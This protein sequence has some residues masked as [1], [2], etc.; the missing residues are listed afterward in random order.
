MTLQWF[1]AR[2]KNL[3]QQVMAKTSQRWLCPFDSYQMASSLM[4]VCG[5]KSARG[6]WEYGRSC[7]IVV[8]RL[9]LN[10]AWLISCCCNYKSGNSTM[11]VGVLVRATIWLNRSVYWD[12]FIWSSPHSTTRLFRDWHWADQGMSSQRSHFGEI[13]TVNIHCTPMCCLHNYGMRLGSKGVM[14]L[15]LQGN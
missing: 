9:W 15:P 12:I 1:I 13:G 4:S 2:E 6:W 11:A 14:W 5:V 3:Y 7:C 8:A 10:M